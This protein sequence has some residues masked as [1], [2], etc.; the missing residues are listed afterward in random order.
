MTPLTRDAR[1]CWQGCQQDSLTGQ[2]L[3][4]THL[5]THLTALPD[6]VE[7][8]LPVSSAGPP[9]KSSPFSPVGVDTAS[10]TQPK[11][12]ILDPWEDSSPSTYCQLLKMVGTP[13][14]GAWGSFPVWP[15]QPSTQSLTSEEALI[16]FPLRPSSCCLPA[17]GARSLLQENLYWRKAHAF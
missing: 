5:G 10:Q 8:T 16:W 1:R 12:R 15:A 14:A 13:G 11:F 9:Q 6:P 2:G 3:L 7:P 17:V 4:Q